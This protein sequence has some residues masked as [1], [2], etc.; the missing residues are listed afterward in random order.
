VTT[1]ATTTE[2]EGASWGE[3]DLKLLSSGSAKYDPGQDTKAPVSLAV[4]VQQKKP[5][6]AEASK[7]DTRVVVIGDSDM[8]TNQ[9]FNKGGGG[10]NLFLNSINWLSLEEDLI[11]IR[12][13][14]P[15]ERKVKFLTGAQARFVRYTSMF[16]LPILITIVGISVWGSRRS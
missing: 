5:E 11:S 3:T 2:T 8:V 7:S 10:G 15:E 9:W 1:L 14:A 16:A 6:S 13:E 12:A 4:A